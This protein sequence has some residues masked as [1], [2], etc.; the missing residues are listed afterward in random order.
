MRRQRH[1]GCNHCVRALPHIAC[2]ILLIL[3]YGVNKNIIMFMRI[4]YGFFSFTNMNN[5]LIFR[6]S[7]K[8]YYNR[9]VIYELIFQNYSLYTTCSLNNLNSDRL[10]YIYVNVLYPLD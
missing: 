5:D 1:G 7:N 2:I 9:C 8:F 10:K 6:F 3:M 4:L